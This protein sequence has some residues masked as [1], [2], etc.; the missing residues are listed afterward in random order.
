MGSMKL[1]VYRQDMPIVP[2]LTYTFLSFVAV[3]NAK[4]SLHRWDLPV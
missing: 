2:A 1:L 3:D 4:L